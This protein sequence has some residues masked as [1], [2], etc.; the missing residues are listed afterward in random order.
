LE[1][2][3]VWQWIFLAAPDYFDR[4]AGRHYRHHVHESTVQAAVRDAV[5]RPADPQPGR[6]PLRPGMITTAAWRTPVA[7][8]AAIQL[9]SLLKLTYIP[10][11][12]SSEARFHEGVWDHLSWFTVNWNQVGLA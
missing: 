10:Q 5:R 6:P 7:T 2:D 11:A 3:W 4:E 9:N 12:P 8:T 1:T